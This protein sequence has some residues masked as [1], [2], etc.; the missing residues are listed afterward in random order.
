L[1]PAVRGDLAR[2]MGRKDEAIAAYRKALKS[3]DLKPEQ[4]FL[5]ARL[6]ELG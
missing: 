4:R 3:V 2:R 1:L 5:A 6:A